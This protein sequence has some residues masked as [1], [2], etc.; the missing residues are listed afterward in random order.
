MNPIPKRVI[1]Q[2]MSVL[3]GIYRGGVERIQADSPEMTSLNRRADFNAV[4]D[5]LCGAD[6]IH[7]FE[8][9]DMAPIITLTDKGKTYLEAN[10]DMIYERRW[11]RG[12]AIAAILI[13]IGSLIVSVIALMK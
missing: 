5:F 7:L 6:L 8:A 12:L 3:V 1:D 2:Y 13:S 4:L 11:T 10:R 9:S